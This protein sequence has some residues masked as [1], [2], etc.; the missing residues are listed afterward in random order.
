MLLSIILPSLL[1]CNSGTE[2]KIASFNSPPV[3]TIISPTNGDV[4]EEFESITFEAQIGDN[5]DEPPALTVNWSSDIDGILTGVLPADPNGVLLYT[6]S[7]L[8]VGNHAITLLVADN[9]GEQTLTY[10]QVEVLSLPDEPTIEILKPTVNDQTIEDQD[11]ELV[12]EVWDARYAL[13]TLL[14]DISS[15][16]DGDLCAVRANS[17]GIASCDAAFS[18]G[19]HELTFVVSNSAGFEA[20]AVSED[21]IVVDL[22]DIDS[23]GD[24]YTT[25]EGDC[26]DEDDTIF[27][28][29]TEIINNTDDDCDGKVDNNTVAYD[30][31]DDGFSEDQGDCDDENASIFPNA[32]EVQNGINDD[33]DAYVDEGTDVF[34][35]DGDCF[36]NTT[37]CTGSIEASCTGNLQGDDCDDSDPAINPAALEICGNTVDENCNT[38][39]NEEDAQGCTTFFRDADGD[40]YGDANFSECWCE[41]SGSTGDFDVPLVQ[42]MS[43][44]CY[45]DN[46]DAKPGQTSFFSVHRG[47][48]LFDYNCDGFETEEWSNLGECN[49]VYIGPELWDWDCQ[50]TTNGWASVAIPA[51]GSPGF[52]ASD[53]SH[54]S[55]CAD[56]CCVDSVAVGSDPVAQ[57]TQ[58]CQ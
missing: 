34:D 56:L 42:T 32:V 58:N 39:T 21:F 19:T 49:S 13:D 10:V 29:Q 11:F 41:P 15:D 54:C 47:D 18:S 27:P 16:I 33:C 14:V 55:A 28:T 23:D 45:D 36:C 7:S 12:A 43:Y 50:P 2:V 51:C 52:W 6:T 8:S 48:G 26:N 25:R 17:Q 38:D 37:P 30:D 53:P 35:D 4:F 20:M 44:D 1:A 24:G 46:A 31:D 3:A 57:R 40:G 9:E 22:D 5:Y